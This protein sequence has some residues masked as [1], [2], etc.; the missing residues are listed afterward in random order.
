[1]CFHYYKAPGELQVKIVE[2]TL[3]NIRLLQLPRSEWP[4]VGCGTAKQQLGKA[5]LSAKW[6]LNRYYSNSNCNVLIHLTV[7]KY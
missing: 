5:W 2:N 4:K 3:I 1:M 6:G 7:S